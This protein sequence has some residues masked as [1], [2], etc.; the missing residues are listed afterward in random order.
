[1]AGFDFL[2]DLFVMSVRESHM[3]ILAG[4]T[5]FMGSNSAKDIFV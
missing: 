3:E 2:G 5:V 1:L 4:D